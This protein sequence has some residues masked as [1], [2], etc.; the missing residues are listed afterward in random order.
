MIVSSIDDV[1][2]V[3]EKN[4]LL[5]Y[6]NNFTIFHVQLHRYYIYIYIYIIVL[7][8]GRKTTISKRYLGRK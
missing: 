3:R 6:S 5:Y 8:H 1:K 4:A 7:C 2:V